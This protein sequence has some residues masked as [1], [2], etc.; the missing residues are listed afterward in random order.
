MPETPFSPLAFARSFR[1]AK[2]SD[3]YFSL[4]ISILSFHF[5]LIFYSFVLFLIFCIG[6]GY[7]VDTT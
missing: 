1:V 6:S 2:G 5:L 3:S 7:N 4:M